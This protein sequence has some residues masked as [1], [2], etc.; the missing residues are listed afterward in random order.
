M[1]FLFV[2]P[3][4]RVVYINVITLGWDTYLSYLKHRV[5]A[6]VAVPRGRA[7]PPRPAGLAANARRLSDFLA[8][9]PPERRARL[10]A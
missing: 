4:Y 2:P 6:G 3:K 8:W 5:S 7:S 1:N 9:Q 10:A